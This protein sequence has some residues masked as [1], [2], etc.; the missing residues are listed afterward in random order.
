MILLRQTLESCRQALILQLRSRMTWVL[1]LLGI[2]LA[3]FS[4]FLP[5]EAAMEGGREV[6]GIS[7]YF[8]VIQFALPVVVLYY[9]VTV[10]H[11]DLSDATSTYHFVRPVPRF[12]LL[13]G[14]WLAV[15][16]LCWGMIAA[17]LSLMYLAIAVPDRP[18]RLGQGVPPGWL[19]SYM[20]GAAMASPGY[21]AVGLL[22]GA[23]FKRPIVVAAA[24]V[25]LS[26]L[27]FSNLPAEAGIRVATIADPLRRWLVLDIAPPRSSDFYEALTGSLHGHEP[28]ALGDPVNSLLTF[29][30][31]ALGLAIWVF[32]RREYDARP[33]D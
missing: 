24:F 15:S 6:Y 29:T 10:L 28:A 11:E 33:K 2:G 9:G 13:L 14:K 7:M 4:W 17:F 31:I 16:L 19:L 32:S 3:F 30:L 26:E 21:A 22:C 1:C 18:W 27:V 25:V 12:S 8:L 20:Q 5:D 23:W